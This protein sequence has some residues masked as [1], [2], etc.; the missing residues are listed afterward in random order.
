M[1]DSPWIIFALRL[2][3]LASRSSY[4]HTYHFMYSLR[5]FLVNVSFHSFYTKYDKHY[6][7]RNLSTYRIY[8]YTT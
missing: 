4:I 2:L 6:L 5:S 3:I 7:L 8:K 1:A